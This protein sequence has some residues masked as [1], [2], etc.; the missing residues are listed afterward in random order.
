MSVSSDNED[1]PVDDDDDAF[2]M[3]IAVDPVE[4]NQDPGEHDHYM[5]NIIANCYVTFQVLVASQR[6]FKL[7]LFFKSQR[8]ISSRMP[9]SDLIILY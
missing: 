5:L 1:L 3:D 7:A 4:E 9:I 8:S 6:Q 2:H